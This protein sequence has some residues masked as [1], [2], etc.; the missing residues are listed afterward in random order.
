MRNDSPMI[1]NPQQAQAWSDI[2]IYKR[3]TIGELKYNNIKL[4]FP[5]SFVYIIDHNLNNN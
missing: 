2:Q 1:W 3:K 4:D 5:S